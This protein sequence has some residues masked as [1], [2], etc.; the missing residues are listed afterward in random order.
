VTDSPAARQATD[1]TMMDACALADAIRAK[2][3]SCVEVMAAYLDRIE[4]LNPRV[5]AIVSLQDRGDCLAQARA[6]DDDLARD[7]YRGW[8]HGFPQAIKDLA[9]TKGIPTAQ[10]SPLLKDFVPDA[11]AIFVERMKAAGSIIIGKTNTPEFGLGSHS[12]NPVFGTTLNAYDQTKTAGGSSGG[13]A[14]ALALRMLP[15]ADGSDHAGSLRNPAAFNN[16]LGLRPCYGRVP[17]NT[18]EVFLPQLGVAGPM[19]RNTADLAQLLAVQAGYDPRVPLSIHEDPAV[20]RAPLGR[21]VKGL[22]LAW[23]GDFGGHLPIE[24]GILDLCRGALQVFDD[25][26]SLVEEVVPDFD[27]ERIWQAWLILRRWQVGTTLAAFYRDP[28]K[29]ALMKPEA[30]WEAEQGAKVS[31]FELSQASAVRSAWYQTVRRLFERFD[32]LLVPTA[33]VFPFDAETRWPEEVMGRR[34]DTYHR[35]MEVVIPVT[36]SGCPAISVPVGFNEAGLPMGMQIV[37]RNHGERAVIEIA[38]AHERATGWVEKKLPPL[39]T[40]D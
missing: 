38:H 29:R 7:D 20:F 32:Y 14:V 10:G 36:M 25:L 5:N 31:A 35:W 22:R 17:A 23:L 18:E 12:F 28:K 11:D 26:G 33:Q 37:G 39:L 9:A 13:A 16:V 4:R 6:R 27:P 30:Q 8:M 3:V 1:I 34:M 15:V 2:K 21:D 24:P 19:A 40:D